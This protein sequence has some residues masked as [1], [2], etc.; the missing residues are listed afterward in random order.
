VYTE[1]PED[2]LGLDVEADDEL[3]GGVRVEEICICQLFRMLGDMCPQ[4]R[5][6]GRA[7]SACP[8]I[9]LRNSP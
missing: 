7:S 9:V 3:G 1:N 4:S 5:T 8:K 6:A 2:F